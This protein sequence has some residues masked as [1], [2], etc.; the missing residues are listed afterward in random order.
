MTKQ[1]EVIFYQ[2]QRKIKIRS[3][4]GNLIKR[5]T[6]RYHQVK[7]IELSNQDIDEAMDF[8]GGSH[9][10]KPYGSVR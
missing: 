5:T 4:K 1:D 9:V 3:Q 8:L 10:L 2:P 7:E 6:A